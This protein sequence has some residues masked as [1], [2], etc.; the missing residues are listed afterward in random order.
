MSVLR[1]SAKG[2][3]CQI[4][5]PFVCNHNRETTVLAHLNGGGMGLK[6]SDIHA[7]FACSDC[8]DLVDGRR[9]VDT[10]FSREEILIYFYQAMIRTQEI[11]LKEGLISYEKTK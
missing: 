7:A 3:D 6:R 4:R 10:E 8:H 11:W 1:N 2:R 9:G 5:V